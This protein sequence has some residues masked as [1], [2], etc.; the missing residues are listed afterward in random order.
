M[1]E[2][3]YNLDKHSGKKYSSTFVLYNSLVPKERSI[4]YH[5][6]NTSADTRGCMLPG[7]T[8]S[9]SGFVGKSGAKFEELKRYINSVGPQNV[10]VI[11]KNNVR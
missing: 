11:I 10:R 7:D 8:Y 1:P 9:G 6:G 2:G 3:L 4:L 5:A